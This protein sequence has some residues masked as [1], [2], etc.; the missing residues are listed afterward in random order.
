MTALCLVMTLNVFT[1]GH[2]YWLQLSGTAMDTPPACFYTTIFFAIHED[3]L[4]PHHPNIACYKRYID[5]VCGVWIPDKDPTTNSSSKEKS[6][7][8]MNNFHNIKW[9]FSPL[10]N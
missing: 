1:F 5:N 6:K 4:L 9:E 7:S 3:N 10:T 2:T 8:S